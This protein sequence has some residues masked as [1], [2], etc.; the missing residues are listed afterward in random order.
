MLCILVGLAVTADA[1][2]IQEAKL[3]QREQVTHRRAGAPPAIIHSHSRGLVDFGPSVPGKNNLPPVHGIPNVRQ[4]TAPQRKQPRRPKG[5]L[6]E[7][8]IDVNTEETYFEVEPDDVQVADFPQPIAR[9]TK[10]WVLVE[11]YFS[12]VLNVIN[13]LRAE[14]RLEPIQS[15]HRKW[16]LMD[17]WEMVEG[18]NEAYKL[19][20]K[21]EVSG[22]EEYA[23]IDM[24]AKIDPSTKLKAPIISS[25][26]PAQAILGEKAL[27]HIERALPRGEDFEE[28]PHMQALYPCHKGMKVRLAKQAFGGMEIHDVLKKRHH[29]YKLG[30]LKLGD[31][32]LHARARYAGNGREFPRQYN[33]RQAFPDCALPVRNQGECG[34]CYAFAT[35]AAVGERLCIHR[36]RQQS[37]N[38]FVRVNSSRPMAD[39]GREE[40]TVNGLDVPARAHT[41]LRKDTRTRQH[42]QEQKKM[43]IKRGRGI[44]VDEVLAP[45]ELVSCGSS[46]NIEYATPYCLLGPGN[47]PIR[48]FSHGCDGGVTLNTIFYAHW[49]GLPTEACSPYSAGGG[50]SFEN[51]FDLDPTA[52]KFPRCE[53]LQEKVCHSDRA[54]HRVGLPQRCSG[55][56]ENCIK[57]AIFNKGPVVASMTVT[58]S[59]MMQY[60][61]DFLDGVFEARAQDP[62]MGGHA[63]VL[64]GWGESTSGIP[65]WIGRNS[66]GEGWGIGEDDEVSPGG[67]FFRIKRGTNEVGIEDEVYFP[68]A[69]VTKR[70]AGGGECVKIEQVH[71]DG[72]GSNGLKEIDDCILTNVCDD[73]VRQVTVSYLGSEG[74]CGSWTARIPRVAPGPG[75]SVAINGAHLC[76]IVEDV[77]VERFDPQSYYLDLTADYAHYGYTCV[78]QNTFPASE[79]ERQICCGN[80]CAHVPSGALGAFSTKFCQDTGDCAEGVTEQTV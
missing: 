56:D 76:N 12:A 69:D 25:V 66:W 22:E 54:R 28:D 63:V 14:Q 13:T 53:V 57:E 24:F 15:D 59:F 29:K 73:S 38:S 65:Y 61:D 77:E 68:E 46:D 1:L 51:H 67:G 36:T 20:A 47:I 10:T 7:A 33:S 62:D 60:P 49:I 50:G 18:K 64:H 74:N 3:V 55:A 2:H 6:A 23:L 44:K 27:R 34:S 26:T 9:S 43:K 42:Q 32:G 17:A 5:S 48:K 58:E 75:N 21:A 72:S 70:S 11:S 19:C 79:G 45:Q 41:F 40:E 35:T 30:H 16:V 31:A 52:G 8:A 78:L 80:A 71:S 4:P 39:G 37:G